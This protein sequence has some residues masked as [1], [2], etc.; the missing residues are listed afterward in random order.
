MAVYN[1]ANYLRTAMDSVFAQEF[2]DYEFVI[3]D[4]GSTDETAEIIQSYGDDR[5][6]YLRNEQNRGQT[7]S[8]NVALKCARG[9]YVGRVD[10]DDYYLPGKL[11]RQVEFLDGHPEVDVC[12]SWA[13]QVDLEGREVGIYRPPADPKDLAFSLLHCSPICHVS[14][15]MRRAPLLEVG[16]Y[17]ERYRYAAD[18]ALWSELYAGGRTLVNMPEVLM[19]YR[20]DEGSFGAG[21]L[22]GGAGDETAEIISRNA[23]RFAGYPVSH[24]EARV[25][26][27]RTTPAAPVSVAQKAFGYLQMS[28]LASRVYGR[29]PARVRAKL[30]SSLVWSLL[31]TDKRA[32]KQAALPADAAR[33]VRSSASIWLAR[34]AARALS[35]LGPARL[36]RLRQRLSHGLA[37]SG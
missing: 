21:A 30:F 16:G 2:R 13:V 27:L 14:V 31:R 12:G 33:R 18:Y 37:R 4:D 29:P 19:A 17:N 36:S 34:C 7:G 25:L 3:V 11:A 6:V 20:S 22:L 32:G 28:D 10:A 9:E 8:L 26:C 15:L 35:G 5:V 1:G 23:S 24:D